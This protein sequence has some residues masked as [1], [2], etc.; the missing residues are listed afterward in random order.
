MIKLSC[1]VKNPTATIPEND[2]QVV[3]A[4]ADMVKRAL[5]EYYKFSSKKFDEIHISIK[6]SE[7]GN[8][9]LVLS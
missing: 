7:D 3:E 1:S 2:D 4:M 8:A 5:Q 6:F 9:N